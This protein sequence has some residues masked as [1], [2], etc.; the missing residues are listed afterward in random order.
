MRVSVLME[1]FLFLMKFR[2]KVS[3]MK[4]KPNQIN[5]EPCGRLQPRDLA[6]GK[7]LDELLVGHVASAAEV[8]PL[9]LEVRARELGRHQ[10]F[11]R[12]EVQPVRIRENC[13]RHHDSRTAVYLS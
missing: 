13:A 2:E 9:S 12:P 7:G 6:E 4:Q 1:I 11:D 8:D 5:L 10:D 3:N